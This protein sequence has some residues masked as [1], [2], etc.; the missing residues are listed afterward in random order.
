MSVPCPP[1]DKIFLKSSWLR[2]NATFAVLGICIGIGIYLLLSAARGEFMTLRQF[3]YQLVGAMCNTLCITNS[4][5]FAQRFFNRKGHYLVSLL[6]YY[7]VSAFGVLLGTELSYLLYYLFF[8]HP[9][10][11]FHIADLGFSF[12]IMLI[13]CTVLY[14]RYAQH[15][16]LKASIRER[17]L[18]VLRL[19]QVTT[20][21]ELATLQA[22]IN[23]HFLY[24]ALNG[25][26]GLIHSDPGKAETMTLQLSRLFRYSLNQNMEN[27]VTVREELEI[28]TTYLE[29]EKVRFGDR[30]EFLLDI[31][32]AALEQKI[33]RF[34]LQPLIE[35]ALKHGLNNKTSGGWMKAS[36][37]LGERI[38]VSVADNGVPFPAEYE[39]GYGLQS[40]YDKLELLY[41]GAHELYVRNAPQKEVLALIPRSA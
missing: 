23:P 39:I 30:I 36:V 12:C 1:N 4:I 18:D 24:N 15:E 21:A 28:V 33:P 14:I 22:K 20:Q 41:P 2:T 31:D 5:Y 32:P 27:L 26:A 13:V 37:R 9:Y 11:F 25:I 6:G 38:E 40:T 16:R 3:R 17:E 7:A 10:Y 35:N 8:G 19:K 34:L 29:I